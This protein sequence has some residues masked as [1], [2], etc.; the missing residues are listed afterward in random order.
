MLRKG[1]IHL[2]LVNLARFDT[3]GRYSTNCVNL[4]SRAHFEV[5]TQFGIPPTDSVLL[6]LGTAKRFIEIVAVR[7][8]HMNQGHKGLAILQLLRHIKRINLRIAAV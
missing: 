5:Y 2:D 4:L 1:G 8:V 7:W 3:D 6:L